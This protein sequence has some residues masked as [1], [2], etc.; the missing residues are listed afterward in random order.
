TCSRIPSGSTAPGRTAERADG[1]TRRP[2]LSPRA[3]ARPR[4]APLRCP[5]CRSTHEDW[6]RDPS[7]GS[8]FF[9]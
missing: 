2:A 3:S 1:L 4:A 8:V 7:A 6:D 5:T 9:D